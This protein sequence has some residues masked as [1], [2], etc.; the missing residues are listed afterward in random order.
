VQGQAGRVAAN[1]PLASPE[2]S[3]RLLLHSQPVGSQLRLLIILRGASHG[4]DRLGLA[5]FH[6]LL[7][8]LAKRIPIPVRPY[9]RMIMMKEEQLGCGH[10]QALRIASLR[11]NLVDEVS[12]QPTMDVGVRVRIA[13]AQVGLENIARQF[14]R[15][16]SGEPP[17]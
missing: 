2:H 17:P 11:T 4:D 16:D 12:A 9:Q 6:V 3:E 7:D 15:A 1:F 10:V 5:W 8:A 14:M 13:P